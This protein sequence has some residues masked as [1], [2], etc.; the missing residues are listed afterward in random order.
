M[1]GDRTQRQESGEGYLVSLDVWPESD[2]ESFTRLQHLT[3]VPLNYRLI[4]YCARRRHI[5]QIFADEK[6]AKHC[7]RWQG[8]KSFDVECH[9]VDECIVGLNVVNGQLT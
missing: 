2:P 7:L 1:D 5:P 8:K 3:A 4:Q 6:I 9:L